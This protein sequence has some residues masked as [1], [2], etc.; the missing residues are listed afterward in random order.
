MNNFVQQG[1]VI[2]EI[3]ENVKGTQIE[4]DGVI[5][6][7]EA[8]GHSH[9][10]EHHELGKVKFFRNEGTMYLDI[11]GNVQV[12]HQEHKKINLPK[13]KYRVHRVKEF[14]HFLEE[15]RNVQD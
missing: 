7:G 4:H 2:F 14:D 11:L 13:G 15:R 5:A 1:D 12:E 10:I 6:E 9:R 8:T 3:V